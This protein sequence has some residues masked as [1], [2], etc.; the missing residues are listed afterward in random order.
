[1]SEQ[2]ICTVIELLTRIAVALESM[3]AKDEPIKTASGA[4]ATRTDFPFE[5]LRYR[6]QKNLRRFR[7]NRE[8]DGHP[9]PW[10]LTC[11]DF[12]RIGAIEISKTQNIGD[13]FMAEIDEAMKKAGFHDWRS[14]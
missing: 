2:N 1:M 14:T 3:A 7:S 8:F 9:I 6:T 13:V 4:Q 11:E 10:P 5:S 12:M